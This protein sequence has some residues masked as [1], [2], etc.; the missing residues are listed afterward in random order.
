MPL[1][2]LNDPRKLAPHT[3]AGFDKKI[4][5]ICYRGQ[6]LHS[7]FPIGGIATGY[8]ELRGDGKLG[9]FSIYN[10]YVP[11]GA[12]AGEPLL[13]LISSDGKETPLDADH[14]DISVL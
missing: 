5:G 1:F 11:Q 12:T 14:A 13:T 9:L 3:V 2:D 7:P 6:D 10:N 4:P 8:F